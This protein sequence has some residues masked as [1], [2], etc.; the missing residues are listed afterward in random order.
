LNVVELGI[1]PTELLKFFKYLPDSYKLIYLTFIDQI[2]YIDN[3]D[4]NLEKIEQ[5]E[6]EWEYKHPD[7]K[8]KPLEEIDEDEDLTEIKKRVGWVR[9]LYSYSELKQFRPVD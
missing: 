6:P 4:K 2:N 5:E 8:I 3:N 9:K 7:Y 1:T